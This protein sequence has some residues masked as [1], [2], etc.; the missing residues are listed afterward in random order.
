MLGGGNRLGSNYPRE[1]R[2][3]TR[4]CQPMCERSIQPFLSS[5]LFPLVKTPKPVCP[6]SY[7]AVYSCTASAAS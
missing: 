3:F 7:C 2:L 4:D 6:S 5:F 1:A